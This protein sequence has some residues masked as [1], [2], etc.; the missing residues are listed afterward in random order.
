MAYRLY[1]TEGLIVKTK[2]VGETSQLCFILT[3]ERGLVVARAEGVRTLASKLRYHLVE[4]AYLRFALVRGREVWRI[5][6]AEPLSLFI[7]STGRQYHRPLLARI[8]A[9]ICRLVHGEAEGQALYREVLTGLQFLATADLPLDRWWAFEY[10]MA[11]RVLYQS[12][13]LPADPPTRSLITSPWSRQLLAAAAPRRREL[14]Q[15]VNH[16]LASNHL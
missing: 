13:Y 8:S 15:L 3:P 6:T 9:L 12:G 10:L 4:S 14:A 7:T 11:L 16:V 5:T 1:H 2:P